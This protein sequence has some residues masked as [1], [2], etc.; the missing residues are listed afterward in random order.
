MTLIAN[1]VDLP[2]PPTP[3]HKSRR[4]FRR[5]I[6]HWIRRGHLY[7]GLFLF[8]WAILYGI[9]GFLFNHP[10]AFSDQPTKSFGSEALAGTPL[11]GAPSP[12]EQAEEVVRKLN[13][14]KQPATAY[15]LA[16]EARYNREFAFA[17]VKVTEKGREQ[18]VSVLV[19]LKNSRGTVRSAPPEAPKKAVEKAPFAVGR[20]PSDALGGRTPGRAIEVER[21]NADAIQLGSP[22]PERVKAAIP[23]ILK[24]TGFPTGEITVTSVPELTI[25][26]AAD[27]RIWTA[28]YNGMTG[29][30]SGKP[31]GTEEKPEPSA[32]RF[33]TRLHSAHGYPGEQDSRWFWAVIVDAMS[34][35]LCCWGLSGL[36][37]WWQIKGTR[38]AG[39]IVLLVSAAA[40]TALGFGMHTMMVG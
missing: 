23:A 31:A 33:L 1:P 16:G 19:D 7:S 17:T 29:S 21:P 28:T 34:F 25:P 9:T 10:T 13:E 15:R 6:L 22:L 20:S 32:R 39:A 26:L 37:M 18:T 12:N 35:A 30:L 36:L 38:I 40:A 14:H 27:G 4:H 3:F 24:S 2:L 8:P 11:E 5:R